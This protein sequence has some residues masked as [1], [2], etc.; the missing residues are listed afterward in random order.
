M[1]AVSA[2]VRVLH[3]QV[4]LGGS[5]ASAPP[6]TCAL[7]EWVLLARIGLA[8]GPAPIGLLKRDRF[9]APLALT[10]MGFGRGQNADGVQEAKKHLRDAMHVPWLRNGKRSGCQTEQDAKSLTTTQK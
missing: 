5:L 2:V 7:A 10:V 4:A 6:A 8:G 1:A 3:M 9:L